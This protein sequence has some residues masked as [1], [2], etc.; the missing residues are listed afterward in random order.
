VQAERRVALGIISDLVAGLGY[1]TR[2]VERDEGVPYATLLVEL[3]PTAAGEPPYQLAMTFY[4]IADEEFSHTSFLQYYIALPLA[5][6]DRTRAAVIELATDINNQLVLG[7]V[8]LTTGLAQVHFRYV[9]PLSADRVPTADDLESVLL[10]VA[11]S[12]RLFD[13]ALAG[14]ADGSLTVEAARAQVAA[15]AG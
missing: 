8:G 3:P 7:H 10:L 4:P 12:I 9:Q 2:I 14:V 6:T 13:R 1:E 5:P 15:A 11:Y